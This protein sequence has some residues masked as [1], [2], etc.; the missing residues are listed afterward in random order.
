MINEFTASL[1][2]VDQ[3]HQTEIGAQ[4]YAKT[5]WDELKNISPRI[6]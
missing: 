6:V 4:Q 3:I 5:I 2:L 1:Y